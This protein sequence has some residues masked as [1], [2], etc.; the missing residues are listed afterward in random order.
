MVEYLQ[1]KR[2]ESM[3]DEDEW[4]NVFHSTIQSLIPNNLVLARSG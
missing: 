3:N 4:M 1:T 2:L